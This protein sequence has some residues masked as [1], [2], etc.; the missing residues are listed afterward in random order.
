MNT[1]TPIDP[2]R[3]PA[4]TLAMTAMLQAGRRGLDRED[5]EGIAAEYDT[6]KQMVVM[7]RLVM[8]GKVGVSWDAEAREVRFHHVPDDEARRRGQILDDVR[9]G[10]LAPATGEE[11]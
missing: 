4:T 3:A 9:S 1:A 6:H 8:A 11:G 2:R 5:L 10:K 7:W